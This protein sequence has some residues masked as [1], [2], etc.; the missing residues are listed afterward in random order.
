MMCVKCGNAWYMMN[1]RGSMYVL[2][3]DGIKPRE[4]DGVPRVFVPDHI[5]FIKPELTKDFQE[6]KGTEYEE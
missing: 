3:D 2:T 5:G 4:P 6:G 1:T